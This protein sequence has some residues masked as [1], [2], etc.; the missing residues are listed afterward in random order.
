MKV[1]EPIPLQTAG[2]VQ[3]RQ[4]LLDPLLVAL[5][6]S[7]PFNHPQKP[8]DVLFRSI[9]LASLKVSL[10]VAKAITAERRAF[11]AEF[12]AVL[13]DERKSLVLRLV[14][15]TIYFGALVLIY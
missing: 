9:P 11:T 13:E 4:H 14:L 10:I 5:R 15:Q 8:S 2:F 7:C 6:R 3:A 12:Q 1:L